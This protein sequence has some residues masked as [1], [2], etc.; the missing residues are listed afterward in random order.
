MSNNRTK[1]FLENFLVY[2][3]GSILAKIAP[4]I[5]LPIVTRLMPDT[6]FY[7]LSDLSNIAVTFGSAIAIMGMYDAMFRMFFERDEF[8][9]KKEVCSSALSY[10]LF[11]GIIICIVLFIFKSYFSVLLFGDEKYANLLNFTSFS[12]LVSA[13]SSIVVAPT[14]MEN[15]RKIF[16]VTSTISPIIGYSVSIPMLLNGNYLY[17]LPTAALVTSA[18]M[19]VFFYGLNR[20]WFVFNKTK[21]PLIKEMLKIGAPLMLGV[22]IYWIFTSCDRLM[23]SKILGNSYVGIY[24]IGARVASVSQIVQVAFAGG[25]QYFAFKTMKD[26][27]QVEMTS[28]IFEYLAVIS[29]S[30]FALV[31][32]F[33]HLIFALFL[34]GD[35]VNGY[36]VF[37]YL[38]LSPLLLMLYQSII[39]QYVIIKKTWPPTIILSVGAISNI[40]L[41]YLL[42]NFNG[43]EGAAIATMLGYVISLITASICLTRMRLVIV[44]KR[45]KMIS[46]ILAIFMIIWRLTSPISIFPAILFSG[47]LS[48]VYFF[49]YKR[50]INIL[51]KKLKI[52]NKSIKKLRKKSI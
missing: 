17:A 47:I 15:R 48:I 23:I 18:V 40:I 36:L 37:P 24:G 1:L 28:K 20:R 26:S 27:D 30:I 39:I 38:F 9:Y 44:T 19:L 12:I 51:L 7:G 45:L 29:F 3:L 2:G 22:I 16:V 49:L 41:N 46:V 5:M 34:T 6:F 35:Y 14:R 42:I 52:F 43:V 4:L 10:V 13:L 21:F 8:E 32:P 25:L 11:S 33:T 50:D 31:L